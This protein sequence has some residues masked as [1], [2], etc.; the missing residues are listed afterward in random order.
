MSEKI[1]LPK[2]GMTMSEAHIGR[3]LKQV[4]DHVSEGEEL[5]E[6][7]SDKILNTLTSPID[8]ILTEI[9]I[10]SDRDVEVGTELAT[11]TPNNEIG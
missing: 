10:P 1:F 9:L 2:W 6:V 3:W 11:I 4:G 5:V 8:G 7:E